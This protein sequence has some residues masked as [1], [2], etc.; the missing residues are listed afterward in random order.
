MD[1]WANVWLKH[2]KDKPVSYY[3]DVLHLAHGQCHCDRETSFKGVPIVYVPCLKSNEN[4]DI[5]PEGFL[6]ER[7]CS[8]TRGDDLIVRT[9][10]CREFQIQMWGNMPYI[11]KHELQMILSDIPEYHSVGR[12]WRPATVPTAA[13]VYA[14]VDLDHLKGDIPKEDL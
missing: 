7:G 14:H 8:I 12:S 13:R 1:S 10:K 4:I 11:K 5:F 9:P 3:Q 6:W 2:E